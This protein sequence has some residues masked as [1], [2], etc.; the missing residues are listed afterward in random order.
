MAPWTW[1]FEDVVEAS[2]RVVIEN[3]FDEEHITTMHARHISHARVLER[4]KDASL[5]ELTTRILGIPVNHIEWMQ[6]FPPDRIVF[7]SR[8]LMNSIEVRAV[9]TIREHGTG[10]R[11]QTE[12]TV[13][14]AWFWR[15]FKRLFLARM[16]A[17]KRKVWE[18]DRPLLIRRN[19]LLRM[20]F[21][22][23]SPIKLM[24]SLP[25]F[26]EAEPTASPPAPEAWLE[27]CPLSE[28][29][30]KG[31]VVRW[32]TPGLEACALWERDRLW[33]FSGVCPH[34]G[35][36]LGEGRCST[37][38][39]MPAVHCPWHGYTFSLTNGASLKPTGLSLPGLP[40]K[41]E[42]GKVYVKTVAP[43]R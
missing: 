22:G 36:P 41:I 17:W 15:P 33:V 3:Y 13:T 20:G 18:E 14:P 28:V 25:G 9:L 19:Q 24:V 26:R 21:R 40:S 2:P 4:G 32:V 7:R 35:G 6:F 39:S 38:D 27:L 30:A 12:Y 43:T 29:Q 8:A 37:H 23:A 16:L 1:H 5:Q 10:T 34:A 11:I 42:D 31:K